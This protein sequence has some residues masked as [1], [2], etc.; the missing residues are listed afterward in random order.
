MADEQPEEVE[1]NITESTEEVVDEQPKEEAPTQESEEAQEAPTESETPE[2]A[3]ELPEQNEPEEKISRRKAK[4]LEK[5]EGLV[6]R[7]RQGEQKPEAPKTGIDYREMITADDEVYKQLE[8]KSAEFGQQQYNA[9]LEQAKT[10]RFHT[11]LDIDAPRVE[12]KYPQFDK[13]SEEFNPAVANAVNQW[14]LATVGYDAQRDAVQNPSIRYADFVESIMELADNMAVTKTAKTTQN[15]AKQAATTGLRPD[16]SSAKRM[17]LSKAPQ[18]M[19][20][21]ELSAAIK[22]TMPRNSKGQ[23]TSQN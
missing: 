5:L 10:I 8:T 14:Y 13:S 21:D 1:Q 11:Q 2:Q 4:R 17:D 9:G 15:I 18:D 7:L 6:E 23:F 3:E 12:S 19:T 20:D 22:A 16:G